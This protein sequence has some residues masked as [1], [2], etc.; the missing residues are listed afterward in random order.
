[1]KNKIKKKLEEISPMLQAHGGD[2]EFVDFEEK[3]G[4][5]KVRLIGMCS[6]CP[7]AGE[8]LKYGI[9][10]ILKKEIKEI[11]KVVSV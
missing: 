8:T 1:M 5:V 4:T 2:V 9:E 6:G 11:K 7:M 3:T 10:E